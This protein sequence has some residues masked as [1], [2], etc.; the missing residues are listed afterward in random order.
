MNPESR[1][2]DNDRSVE[3]SCIAFK[4]LQ[5]ILDEGNGWLKTTG[6]DWPEMRAGLCAK[7]IS[8]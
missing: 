6:I 2:P 7:D 4:K 5:Q 1:F 3:E 8:L